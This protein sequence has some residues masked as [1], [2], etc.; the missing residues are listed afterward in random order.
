MKNSIK[1][2]FLSTLGLI[3]S[4]TISSFASS[5]TKNEEQA[6]AASTALVPVSQSSALVAVANNTALTLSVTQRA[7][8]LPAFNPPFFRHV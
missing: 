7:S 3:V 6:K 8:G 4:L 2:F 1:Y 5:D